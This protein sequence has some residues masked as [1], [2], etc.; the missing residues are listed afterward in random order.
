[1]HGTCIDADRITPG[2]VA[3]KSVTWCQLMKFFVPI[4]PKVRAE[5]MQEFV[6]QGDV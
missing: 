1:M 6:F 3:N 5:L 4:R 2:Q